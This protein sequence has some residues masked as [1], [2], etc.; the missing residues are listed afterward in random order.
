MKANLIDGPFRK[1]DYKIFPTLV[2]VYNI[3]I[4][5]NELNYIEKF[6]ELTEWPEDVGIG[7]T[8]SQKGRSLR[9]RLCRFCSVWIS[10]NDDERHREISRDFAPGPLFDV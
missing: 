4:Q 3:D 1:A 6:N 5:P 8:S 10:P 9:R 7:K 2:Q